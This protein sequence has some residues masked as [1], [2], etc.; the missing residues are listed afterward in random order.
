MTDQQQSPINI[1]NAIKADFGTDGL[2]IEW[3]GDIH[4][5]V[6]HDDH[7][8]KVVFASDCR[9]FLTLCGT[10]YFLRQFHFHH[11][12]EHWVDGEQHTMELHIVH[13]NIDNGSLAVIGIFI[14]PGKAKGVAPPLVSQLISVLSTTSEACGE[15]SG[16]T[17]PRDFLPITWQKHYR[18]EGSLTTPPYSENV[19]WVVVKEP[20]EIPKAELK[21]LMG[22]FKAEARFPQPLNRRY[23]LKTFDPPK[24]AR[25]K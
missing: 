18:Y 12:S 21:K 6:Q 13:Q 17:D 4:G 5:H 23:V 19:S 14:E 1:T 25:G 22:V 2:H 20:L 11:P 3:K 24:P 16:P 15:P 8:V 10:R 7:G 9:Q